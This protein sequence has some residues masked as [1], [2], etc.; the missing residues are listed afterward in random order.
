MTGGPWYGSAKEEG[1]ASS[2][3]MIHYHCGPGSW[4]WKYCTV[5]HFVMNILVFYIMEGCSHTYFSAYQ[6]ISSFCALAK[7]RAII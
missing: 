7:D 6:N 1:E 5:S 4:T 3:E 2:P